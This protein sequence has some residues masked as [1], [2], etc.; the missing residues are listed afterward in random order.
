MSDAERAACQAHAA[1]LRQLLADRALIT[2]GP[3]LGPVNAGTA[4]FQVLSQ[5]RTQQIFAAELPNSGVA[6]QAWE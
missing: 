5:E 4:I 2:A 3:R 6:R 1:W